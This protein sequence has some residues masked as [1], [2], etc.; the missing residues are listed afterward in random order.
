MYRPAWGTEGRID[1]KLMH[2]VLLASLS[3][4]ALASGSVAVKA[5]DISFIV[6]GDTIDPLYEGY[7][8]EWEAARGTYLATGR[9]RVRDRKELNWRKPGQSRDRFHRLS[10]H[11]FGRPWSGG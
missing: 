6:C 1:L 3:V 2:S 9:E 8:K 11:R 7:I 5:Q 10:R 4:V